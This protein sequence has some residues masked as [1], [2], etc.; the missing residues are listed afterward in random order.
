MQ[1]QTHPSWI[2]WG[3]FASSGGKLIKTNRMAINN[4]RT[5]DNAGENHPRSKLKESDII[6]I[7]QMAAGG[8]SR[9]SISQKFGVSLSA[10]SN[11]VARKTWKH[12]K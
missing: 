11:I 2:S 8:C 3:F 10:V 5:R 4:Y 7:R 1:F 6:E 12:L 9:L